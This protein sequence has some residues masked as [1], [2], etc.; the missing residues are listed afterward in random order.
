MFVCFSFR[1]GLCICACS[2][3]NAL[4]FYLSSCHV[5]NPDCVV[6]FSKKTLSVS[7]TDNQIQ[8]QHRM[9]CVGLRWRKNHYSSHNSEPHYTWQLESRTSILGSLS[10]MQTHLSVCL[11]SIW[12]KWWGTLTR[13]SSNVYLASSSGAMIYLLR[14]W[15]ARRVNVIIQTDMF[16]LSFLLVL[17]KV[18]Y[19]IFLNKEI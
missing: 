16:S 13:F 10:L 17:Q 15:E 8:V 6:I 1:V 4:S 12:G 7:S 3:K 19:C 11:A 9:L 5:L 2:F 14:I 18:I